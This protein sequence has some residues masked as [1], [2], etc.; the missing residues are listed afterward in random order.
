MK[1]FLKKQIPPKISCIS[2]TAMHEACLTQEN[3]A[4]SKFQNS[5]GQQMLYV[6]EGNRNTATFI[7]NALWHR[8]NGACP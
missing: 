8:I 7:N 3:L 4:K 5:D 2:W 6:P 1:S